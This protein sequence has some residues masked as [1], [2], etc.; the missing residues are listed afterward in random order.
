MDSGSHAGIL[1]PSDVKGLWKIYIWQGLVLW[2]WMNKR[3][4]E[5]ESGQKTWWPNED[6]W[7]SCAAHLAVLMVSNV[8]ERTDQSKFIQW[9]CTVESLDT[10]CIGA[11]FSVNQLLVYHKHRK[12][13]SGWKACPVDTADCL[14]KR[15][16]KGARLWETAILLTNL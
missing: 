3:E 4:L 15:V 2:N 16:I 10:S 9:P 5:G 14:L 7:S 11:L 12:N 6:V 8:M 13:Q 1:Q